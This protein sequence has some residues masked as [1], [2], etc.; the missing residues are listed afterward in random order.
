MGQKSSDFFNEHI[1][2]TDDGSIHTWQT[3][4]LWKS[5]FEFHDDETFIWVNFSLSLAW[6]CFSKLAFLAIFR[7]CFSMRSLPDK[8]NTTYL[9]HSHRKSLRTT[10]FVCFISPDV[11]LHKAGCVEFLSLVPFVHV[12]GNGILFESIP[13]REKCVQ[14]YYHSLC[15]FTYI[16][17]GSQYNISFACTIEIQFICFFP[18]LAGPCKPAGVQNEKQGWV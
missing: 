11:W 18:H 12:P 15:F 1:I 3:T 6:V 13:L 8:I 7:R 10:A 4:S 14:V 17:A 2:C 16:T 9:K 5:W